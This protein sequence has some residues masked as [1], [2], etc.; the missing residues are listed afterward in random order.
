MRSHRLLVVTI[1]WIDTVLTVEKLAQ[2]DATLERRGEWLRFHGYTWLVW[3]TSTP[4]E[5]SSDLRTLIKPNDSIMVLSADPQY[6][7]GWAPEWVWKW[8]LEKT[9][10]QNALNALMPKK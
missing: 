2:V 3:T 8:L 5:I 4:A 9:N 1:R 7:G 10:Q 6:A